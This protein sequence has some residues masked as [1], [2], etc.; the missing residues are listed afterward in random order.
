MYRARLGIPAAVA[1]ICVAVGCGKSS[2]SDQALTTDI[3]SKL[4]ADTGTKPANINVAVKDGAVTLSGDVPSSDVELQAV[5][6]A[7][8]TAGVKTVSNSSK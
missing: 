5:K 1:I 8:G 2:S 3:Q 6:I 4:Y 7:N